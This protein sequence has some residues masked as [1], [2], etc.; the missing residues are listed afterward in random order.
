MKRYIQAARRSSDKQNIYTVCEAMD[1]NFPTFIDRTKMGFKCKWGGRTILESLIANGAME[2]F[3]DENGI[4]Y[5]EDASTSDLRDIMWE[6]GGTHG[7]YST[8]DSKKYERNPEVVSD[9]HSKLASIIEDIYDKT[10][11]QC[12]RTRS[13][14][15]VVPY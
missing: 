4:N 5:P 12:M 8:Y 15:L 9:A 11:I 14:N 10:G 3:L 13:G 6:H 7:L 2:K 1:W